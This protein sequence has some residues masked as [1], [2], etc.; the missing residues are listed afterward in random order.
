MPMPN[1]IYDEQGNALRIENYDKNPISIYD[2]KGRL[3]VP[4]RV[5]QVANDDGPNCDPDE[6]LVR[7]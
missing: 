6:D 3:L 5:G 7:Y 2:S 4:V 1:I